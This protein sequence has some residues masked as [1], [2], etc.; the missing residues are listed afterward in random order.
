[1]GHQ[2]STHPQPTLGLRSNASARA[3]SLSA[4]PQFLKAVELTGGEFAEAVDWVAA[5]WLPGRKPVSQALAARHSVHPSGKIM[6]LTEV[7]FR[8]MQV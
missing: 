8:C 5:G 6:L 3:P 1:M 4:R 7:R 2:L